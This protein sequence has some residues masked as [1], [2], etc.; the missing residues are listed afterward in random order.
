MRQAGFLR[1]GQTITKTV[2]VNAEMKFAKIVV[3]NL[4]KSEAAKPVKVTAKVGN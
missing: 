2:V 3:E 4:D 1:A